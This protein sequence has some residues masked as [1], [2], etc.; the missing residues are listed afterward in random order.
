MTNRYR[1]H[2]RRERTLSRG[3]DGLADIIARRRG[4]Y[5]RRYRLLLLLLGL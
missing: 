4:N 1:G 2:Q 5:R 3:D